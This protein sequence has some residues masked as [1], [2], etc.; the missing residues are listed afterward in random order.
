MLP[1]RGAVLEVYY[2]FSQPRF[3]TENPITPTL[4]CRSRYFGH[5]ILDMLD[6][7]CAF[8]IGTSWVLMGFRHGKQNI[9]VTI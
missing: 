6:A 5:D 2:H 8:T 4:T 9:L 3:I 1:E 7:F